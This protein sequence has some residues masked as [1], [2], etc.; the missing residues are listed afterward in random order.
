MQLLGCI[1]RQTSEFQATLPYIASP[2]TASLYRET[3]SKVNIE[4]KEGR[5]GGRKGGRRLLTCVEV[6]GHARITSLL[7]SWVP[8]MELR[9]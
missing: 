3:F 7:P 1:I 8:G 2:R 4:R 9:S 5:K 6:C